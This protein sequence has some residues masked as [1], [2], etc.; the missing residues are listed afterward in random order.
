MRPYTLLLCLLLPLASPAR[1]AEVTILYTTDLHGHVLPTRDYDGHDNVGGLLKVATV[2]ERLRAEHPNNL[3][4]DCGDL[5]QGGAESFLTDGR[6]TVKACEFLKY[7]TWCLGNHEF[8]WGLDK[9]AALHDTTK[10]TMIGANIGVRPGGVNR[11][12]KVRPFV[13]KEVDGI[14]IAIVG[15]ITPGVPSWSRSYLL[16][17]Q[18]FEDSLTALNRVMPAVRAAEPDVIVLT[19]HQGLRPQDDYANEIRAIAKGFPEIKFIIG[20]HSHRVVPREQIGETIFTQ[21][22]YYGAWVGQLD[23]AYDTVEHRVISAAPQI[24]TVDAS[25]PEH[26][27]LKTLCAADLERTRKYLGEKIGRCDQLLTAK[28]DE[29]G[30]SPAQMLISRAVAAVADADIVLHGALAEDPL[31]AG[32]LTMKDIWTIAPYENT[33]GVIQITPEQIAMILDENGEK[34]GAVHFMGAFGLHYDWEKQADGKRHAVHLRTPAGEPLHARRK[35]RVALH[36]YNLASGG[37]RFPTIRTLADL[38]ESRLE[39]T[40]IDTRTALINYVK[41]NSPL[42]LGAI[43]ESA[44]R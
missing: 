2:V 27:G 37:R 36:S 17:D 32:E 26:D 40:G 16:G 12:S 31:P 24:H 4:V 6:L 34:P 15:L 23:I 14:K 13:L 42:K 21:A 25:V 28:P 41:K 8:D 29:Y 44:R 10:L 18:L 30:Q 39:M 19:T 7:D 43:M 3:L 22:G 20:G 5:Y 9:L 35:Y 1:R 33:I 38:P 11:L